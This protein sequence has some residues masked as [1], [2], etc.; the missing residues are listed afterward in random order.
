MLVF[1]FLINEQILSGEKELDSRS[2]PR[3]GD[4]TY[5]RD[6][7]ADLQS[8]LYHAPNMARP[9]INRNSEAPLFTST[10]VQCSPNKT[11]KKVVREFDISHANGPI[12]PSCPS[13]LLHPLHN[14]SL[15]PPISFFLPQSFPNRPL[16]TS[17]L[18]CPQDSRPR[19]PL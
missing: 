14:V 10:V 5:F 4:C 19:P 18:L 16:Q 1:F 6:Y 9:H 2:R 15:P 11:E 8:L 7:I 13:L 12:P 17:M 3:L